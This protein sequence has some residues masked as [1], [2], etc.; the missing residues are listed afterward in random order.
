MQPDL[1]LAAAGRRFRRDPW[2]LAGK[3]DEQAT[4]GPGMLDRDPQQR[5]D[6]LAEFDLARQRL[7]GLEHCSNIQLLG[8]RANGS[9]GRCRDW[10]VARSEEHTSELQSRRELV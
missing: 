1:N 6:E 10:C 3:Q 8:G 4:L 7:R 9:G 2:L 5:L